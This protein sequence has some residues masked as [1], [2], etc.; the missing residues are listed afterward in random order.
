MIFI[1]LYYTCIFK[2]K[3]AQSYLY[4]NLQNTL[5]MHTKAVINYHR[6]AVISAVVYMPYFA[7]FKYLRKSFTL[8]GFKILW[9]ISK[10]YRINQ[11]VS[12]IFENLRVVFCIATKKY[13]KSQRSCSID[14][15]TDPDAFLVQPMDILYTVS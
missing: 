4:Y 13:V 1:S 12:G 10:Q 3:N 11:A 5:R 6:N 7:V 9:I 2:I 8:Y 14:K 15:W